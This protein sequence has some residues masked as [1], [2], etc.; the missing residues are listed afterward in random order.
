MN[1]DKGLN[2]ELM[3]KE[4]MKSM[5]NLPEGNFPK[6]KVKIM[7]IEFFS[8]QYMNMNVTGISDGGEWFGIP[9]KQLFQGHDED[10][11]SVESSE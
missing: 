6:S 9:W 11:N 5:I 2:I 1:E 7:N 3:T 8:W 10:V 4:G